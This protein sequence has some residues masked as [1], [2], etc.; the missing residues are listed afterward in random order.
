MFQVSSLR[1]QWLTRVVLAQST[2]SQRPTSRRVKGI[3]RMHGTVSVF[4]NRRGYGF[5][6]AK[7]FVGGPPVSLPFPMDRLLDKYFFT[8]ASLSGGFR[9]NEGENVSFEIWERKG[10]QPFRMPGSGSF[11]EASSMT[12]GYVPLH[13]SVSKPIVTPTMVELP[14][15]NFNNDERLLHLAMRMCFY[16]I[17]TNKE[18]SISPTSLSGKVIKWDP[19]EGRGVIS[20]LD[21]DG[22]F[23]QDA[24]CF[25]L[26]LDVMDISP[27]TEMRVGRYVR[28]CVDEEGKHDGVENFI[29]TLSMGR[30]GVDDL[31]PTTSVTSGE[32]QPT[33]STVPL[34]Q[35]RCAIIDVTAERT[36]AVVGVPIVPAS[37]PIGTMNESTRFSGT[38][39]LLEENF[40]FV[41]DDLEGDSI[42]F[43][44]SNVSSQRLKVGERVTYLLRMLNH[45]KHLGKKAC[46]D[47]RRMKSGEDP[48]EADQSSMLLSH[49]LH[50]D[51]EI[52][53]SD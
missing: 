39:R 29:P 13:E 23:H 42:F 8:R 53:F 19:I 47:M 10:A 9:V 28:F 5:V 36:N 16:D 45:G 35:A 44:L 6:T 21:T 31:S 46:F 48:R 34:R 2:H 12:T 11:G 14:D 51:D 15:D 52:D 38:I 41:K 43:H 27:G 3:P 24:P 22:H 30:K 49:S 20:E 25:E 4:K 17:E 18:S 7:G 40:G 32:L 1:F 33:S 50:D 37:A 26:T